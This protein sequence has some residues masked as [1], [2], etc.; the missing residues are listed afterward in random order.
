MKLRQ[1]QSEV[2]QKVNRD[3]DPVDIPA[4]KMKQVYLHRNDIGK[5]AKETTGEAQSLRARILSVSLFPNIYNRSNL[6]KN[7]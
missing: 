4:Y 2:V 6:L 1:H 5:V 7:I 3:I